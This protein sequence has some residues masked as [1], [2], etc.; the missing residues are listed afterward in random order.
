MGGTQGGCVCWYKSG[1]TTGKRVGTGRLHAVGFRR[2]APIQFRRSVGKGGK[3]R[4]RRRRPPSRQAV[5][6]D[7][8]FVS[9][10]FFF[11]LPSHTYERT[12]ERLWH[13]V[14]KTRESRPL[15]LSPP[16][17]ISPLVDPVA[18]SFDALPI[19][20][21]VTVGIAPTE[22]KGW[23]ER[24]TRNISWPSQQC[25]GKISFDES[26]AVRW[27]DESCYSSI[28]DGQNLISTFL[29][30]RPWLIEW[31]FFLT[32]YQLLCSTDLLPSVLTCS[33]ANETLSL[34]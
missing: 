32:M 14:E 4:R 18:L 15:L 13:P 31:F 26:Y 22:P 7:S 27:F 8:L 30:F 29:S 34:Y 20:E 12:N 33:K 19:Y 9:T 11:P 5:G 1:A 10:R 3:V 23:I 25:S 21:D 24:W 28:T 17:L 16:F 6:R 2:I